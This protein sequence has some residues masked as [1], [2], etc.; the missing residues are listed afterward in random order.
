MTVK[1]P[2]AAT[3]SNLVGDAG[4]D[5]L[6]TP[7]C[8]ASVIHKQRASAKLPT[9]LNLDIHH[10]SWGMLTYLVLAAELAGN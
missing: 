10:H 3:G 5:C 6:D 8:C 9:A 4:T 1:W 7:S 2:K